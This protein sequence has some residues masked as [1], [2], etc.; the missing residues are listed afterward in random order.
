MLRS[1]N[2]LTR[3][4]EKI[5]DWFRVQ[6]HIEQKSCS[7]NN[8]TIVPTISQL[9][10]MKLLYYVQGVSLAFYGERAFSNPIYAWEYGPAI[11]Q[12]H[13]EYRGM[14]QLPKVNDKAR[15]NYWSVQKNTKLYQIVKAVNGAYGN[16]SAYGLMMQTHREAP[17][18]ETSQGNEIPVSLIQ[19]YFN[20]H[21]V[22]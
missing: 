10:V 4:I 20:K 14:V 5:V 18:R 17:W 8:E 3:D 19:D 11:S 2:V 7:S 9:K 6:N 22:K 21:I 15:R 1:K 12:V 13:D 16:M